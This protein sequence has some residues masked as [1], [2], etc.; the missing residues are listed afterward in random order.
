LLLLGYTCK[1]G[2]S[3]SVYI[4]LILNTGKNLSKPY[5]QGLSYNKNDT[6]APTN[7]ILLQAESKKIFD[8]I[9]FICFV[10]HLYHAFETQV[11]LQRNPSLLLLKDL[12]S[13]RF[14]SA[15]LNNEI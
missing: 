14:C 5:R 7:L 1:S 12:V 3:V 4:C 8:D 9:L 15:D 2:I 11:L 10:V 6:S 13:V